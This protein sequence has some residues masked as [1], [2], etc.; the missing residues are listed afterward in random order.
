MERI[1]NVVLSDFRSYL[2]E[3][4]FKYINELTP[5]EQEDV[6]QS[7]CALYQLHVPCFI[8]KYFNELRDVALPEIAVIMS[9]NVVLKHPG[10]Q[11]DLRAE[12]EKRYEA[13]I[14]KLLRDGGADGIICRLYPL[15]VPEATTAN[16]MIYSKT[17]SQNKVIKW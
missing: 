8:N 1:N 10:A 2:H 6:I 16:T 3:A 15:E 17:V 13:L 12:I 11:S 9:Y 5:I 14:V 7:A 4:I